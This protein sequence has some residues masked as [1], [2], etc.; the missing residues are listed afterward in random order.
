MQQ[1]TDFV[2]RGAEGEGCVLRQSLQ[3][4][5]RS[6]SHSSGTRSPGAPLGPTLAHD[7]PVEGV[8]EG[9]GE[10]DL[11]AV[12]VQEESEA[13]VPALILAAQQAAGTRRCAEGEWTG[14]VHQSAGI[15]PVQGKR[16]VAASRRSQ[17]HLQS[18]RGPG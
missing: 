5:S 1:A 10:G 3:C 7:E 6:G 18:W 11:G 16:P 15:H 9:E 2:N 12:Q 4:G 8:G 13:Q 17:T 14:G